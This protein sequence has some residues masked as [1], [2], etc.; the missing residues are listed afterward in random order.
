[1]T[2]TTKWLALGAVLLSTLPS[3][4]QTSWQKTWAD[5]VARSKGQSLVIAIH[6]Y[7]AN[8]AVVQAFKKRYPHINVQLTQMSA[9]QFVPRIMKEQ[10]G[11]IFAWDV[12][13][14]QVSNLANILVPA[15]GLERITDYLILPEVVS[16]LH[17]RMPRLVHSADKDAFIF[18]FSIPLENAVYANM[19]ILKGQNIDLE[20]PSSLLDPR[21]KG[22]IAIRSADKSAAGAVTLAALMKDAGAQGPQLVQSLLR[23]TDPVV[24]DNPR[25]I[26][27]AVMR[28]DKAIVLGGATEIVSQCQKAGGCRDIVKLSY[29][30]MLLPRGVAVLKRAPHKEATKVWVNWLL[31][32]DGQETYVREMGEASAGSGVSMR[33]DVKPWPGH[34]DSMPDYGNI[35]RW[36]L[37]GSPASERY[38]TEVIAISR[39]MKM[40]S[41]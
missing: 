40:K 21:L 4:A 33:K 27:N 41:R 36:L 38:V 22:K 1:M 23:D 17:W 39:K 8:V 15:G 18:N 10:Q 13:M 9:N 30:K 7:T 31:S 32:K 28:G 11:G 14:G 24:M 12:W 3:Y 26:T 35:E 37:I 20:N 29:A 25:Q 16:P 6:P 19:R 2:R 5:T 34:E